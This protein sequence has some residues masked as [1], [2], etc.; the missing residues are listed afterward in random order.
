M[1][2]KYLHKQR[3]DGNGGETGACQVHLTLLEEALTYVRRPLGRDQTPPR[4]QRPLRPC[5][6][7]PGGKEATRP[8]SV[9]G[10]RGN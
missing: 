5:K 10:F 1:G 3:K 2:P 6:H 7:R 4:V 8:V 9:R